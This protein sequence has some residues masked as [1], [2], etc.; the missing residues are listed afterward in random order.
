VSNTRILIVLCCVGLGLLLAYG[1]RSQIPE[2]PPPPAEAA[3]VPA[4][5]RKEPPIP[6]PPPDVVSQQAQIE[7]KVASQQLRELRE[8]LRQRQLREAAARQTRR[9]W[10]ELLLRSEGAVR[11]LIDTNLPTFEAQRIL[12]LQEDD[13]ELRCVF[14]DGDALLDFCVV[15]N[16]TGLC[17]TCQ[18]VGRERFEP[19]KPCFTCE[20]RTSCFYCAGRKKMKCVFCENGRITTITPWPSYRLELP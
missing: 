10:E 19:E 5:R 17:P 16:S 1:M 20:G 4:L 9:R 14:C 3:S 15:C 2:A 7:R 8:R 13:K 12:A 6:S 11:Q 18:G